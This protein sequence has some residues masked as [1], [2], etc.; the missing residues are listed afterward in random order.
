MKLRI[1]ITN[2]NSLGVIENAIYV[3]HHE[4]GNV[5]NAVEDEV[6]IR[7]NQACHIHAFVKNAEIVAFA[8]EVLDHFDHRALS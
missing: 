6:P 8:D 7:A 1:L 3:V 2:H 4:A 5:R